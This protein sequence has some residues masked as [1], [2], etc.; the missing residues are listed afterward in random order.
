MQNNFA[1]AI[2]CTRV[3]TLYSKKKKEERTTE[4]VHIY[5]FHFGKSDLSLFPKF[6]HSE[7]RK[8]Y[9]IFHSHSRLESR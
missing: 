7:E 6:I 5:H 2:N 8:R 4:N 9:E 1:D 3:V